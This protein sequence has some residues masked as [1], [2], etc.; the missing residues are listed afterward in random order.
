M[1]QCL[2]KG[3]S[4]VRHSAETERRILLLSFHT[5]VLLL[6]AG[7]L[8]AVSEYGHT[9]SC[10]WAI[11]R[12]A[13]LTLPI[14]GL[15]LFSIS[16]GLLKNVRRF[17]FAAILLLVALQVFLFLLWRTGQIGWY[18]IA[19]ILAM[20]AAGFFHLRRYRN[21]AAVPGGQ[22]A[23]VAAD[24]AQFL[25]FQA[26][27][28]T[29][30]IAFFPSQGII[31]LAGAA[32][33]AV[34]IAVMGIWRRAQSEPDTNLDTRAP[35]CA[36]RALFCAALLVLA[37]LLCQKPPQYGHY[38][39]FMGPM[40]DV[41]HGKSLLGETPSIYGYLNIH[42]VARLLQCFGLS[43]QSFHL[44]NLAFYAAY[45]TAFIWL[46]WRLLRSITAT[47]ACAI[48]ILLLQTAFAPNISA[49]FPSSG[50]L[51]F[52]PGLAMAAL[53]ITQPWKRAHW[54]GSMVCAFS[55]FFSAEAS[56]YTCPAW[57]TCCFAHAWIAND[58][59]LSR[60]RNGLTA[61]LP[62]I[63]MTG[64]LF[65]WIYF[66]EYRSEYGWP[67]FSRLYEYALAYQNVSDAAQMRP[68]GKQYLLVF[69]GLLGLTQALHLTLSRKTTPLLPAAAFLAIHNIAIL[70]Y[71][72]V[73]SNE[74]YAVNLFFF[75]ILQGALIFS[76]L[77]YAQDVPP[78][79]AHA[80]FA[81][82][83]ILFFVL[84]V[85]HSAVPAYGH[86]REIPG[87]LAKN[88]ERGKT[89]GGNPAGTV[90][91][92]TQ[93][94]RKYDIAPGRLAMF[95][96][97][98]DTKLLLDADL[99]NALPFNPALMTIELPGWEVE[100]LPAALDRLEP[101]MFF[102]SVRGENVVMDPLRTWFDID[103]VDTL[104]DTALPPG[105][106]PHLRQIDLDVFRIVRRYALPLSLQA[107]FA[108]ACLRD[109]NGDLA[110]ALSE[111]RAIN[112]LSPGNAQ[113]QVRLGAALAATHPPE[114]GLRV[115][116]K[117][118]RTDL[119]L[120]K[121]AAQL[122]ARRGESFV[123]NGDYAEALSV[124]STAS[125][126]Q[127][128]EL[129]HAVRMG[130]IHVKL[131]QM[132]SALE[133]FRAVMNAAPESP[134]TAKLIDS[135][136]EERADTQGLVNEWRSLASA[137]PNAFEPR[138]RLARALHHNEEYSAAID[139]LTT[140]DTQYSGNAAIKLLLGSADVGL[141]KTAS[142]LKTMREAVDAD[143]ALTQKAIQLSKHHAARLTREG[144]TD[145][146]PALLDFALKLDPSQEDFRL[147][148]AETLQEQGSINDAT[149]E[150]RNAVIRDP[151]S[152]QALKQLNECFSRCYDPAGRVDAWQSLCAELP[153]AAGPRLFLAGA[154]EAAGRSDEARATYETLYA[155]FPGRTEVCLDY[156][157][158]LVAKGRLL[159]A[160][161]VLSTSKTAVRNMDDETRQL[162]LLMVDAYEKG[163]EYDK[164][165][166][167]LDKVIGMVPE[168]AGLL[169]SMG[170]V[171]RAQNNF[172]EAAEAYR[173]A[174]KADP[175][176]R[177]AADRLEQVFLERNDYA[178][179]LHEWETIHAVCPTAIGPSLRLGRAMERT[180]NWAEAERVFEGIYRISP[181]LPEAQI[182][183][184]RVLVQREE[185]DESEALLDKAIAADV[186]LAGLALPVFDLLVDARV[187][188]ERLPEAVR[189]IGK[190]I[191]L[192]PQDYR[193]HM[194]LGEIH[195][196]AKQ[197][198]EAL[199]AYRAVMEGVLEAPKTAERIDAILDRKNGAAL[200]EQEWRAVV[201]RH[202]EAVV[203]RLRL[204]L[205]LAALNNLEEARA[206][207]NE[208]ATKLPQGEIMKKQFQS[209]QNALA[210]SPE[211][212]G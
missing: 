113:V 172:S 120:R 127:P 67:Q 105:Q 131:G 48:V 147:E 137:F 139:L 177:F 130:E 145:S 117:A 68:F 31:L 110:G 96:V 116:M 208:I 126:L 121:P 122:C 22:R 98:S 102:V 114:E 23:G 108:E 162:L 76:V 115:I 32:V 176:S 39:T 14:I 106:S 34:F 37:F 181:E 40:L 6:V 59:L 12:I 119:R 150:V 82:P 47:A 101:G 93:L 28:A 103:Y 92:L 200:R 156:A 168:D 175:E 203:P 87:T 196:A 86:L 61:I 97:H 58:R 186:G 100:Y 80:L 158:F 49:L 188:Q 36:R 71:Y 192:A 178:G 3:F 56:F 55:I 85:L 144:K 211:P 74:N 79:F 160:Q 174:I 90:P 94:C 1:S 84:F 77:R 21:T 72:I 78:K 66:R 20:V 89:R 197:D 161:R 35:H 65:I 159:D 210:H 107:R 205:A 4:V 142:G 209:L 29:C 27:S 109:D 151:E 95:N 123:K 132:S 7:T 129:W 38:K 33:S 5:G 184:A 99:A 202:P 128:E 182:S 60:I 170:D 138:Y 81:A 69:V 179:L 112:E 45:Y 25:T 41:L 15:F 199:A 169:V 143:P 104:S 135:I 43:A 133:L 63:A 9:E 136:Y 18:Q 50:C 201:A 173:A 194:K 166:A 64:A 198:D 70:S 183:Y 73:Q 204:A 53:L 88:F 207:S 62:T 30:V 141:G 149:Q 17:V 91:L 24:T 146:F 206:I 171:A 16:N 157:N 185:L 140:L 163:G 134:Y 19:A 13:A 167:L 152:Q 180:G 46:V 11:Y 51:R 190:A 118:M 44:F 189:L 125:E 191:A 2:R 8:L 42:L 57:F 155:A 153:N 26:L 193:R 54:L 187:K 10:E 75:Y 148:H 83:C 124:Y 52:G 165:T 154:L 212:S 195:E 111:Y 164:A